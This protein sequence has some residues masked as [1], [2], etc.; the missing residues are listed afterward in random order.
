MIAYPRPFNLGWKMRSGWISPLRLGL[1]C[2]DAHTGTPLTLSVVTLTSADVE[3]DHE[4]Q[5]VVTKVGPGNIDE[6]ETS[7]AGAANDVT[8]TSIVESTA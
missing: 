8:I 1:V 6:Q 5:L 7:A 2:T 3:V 4:T